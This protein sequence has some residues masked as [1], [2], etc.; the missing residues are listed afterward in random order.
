MDCLGTFNSSSKQEDR[1]LDLWSVFLFYTVMISLFVFICVKGVKTTFAEYYTV[2][3]N[4]EGSFCDE[5]TVSLTDEESVKKV[6][7]HNHST[8]FGFS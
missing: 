7:N 6:H 8:P 1:S 5:L 2:S 4:K 3:K